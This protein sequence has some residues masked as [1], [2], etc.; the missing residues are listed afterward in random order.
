MASLIVSTEEKP[1]KSNLP[2]PFI[3]S[4]SPPININNSAIEVHTDIHFTD[5][6]YSDVS[7]SESVNYISDNNIE[8]SKKSDI[9]ELMFGDLEIDDEEKIGGWETNEYFEV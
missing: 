8:N 1:K 2:S 4:K 3:V 5:S 9:S 6:E 7:S